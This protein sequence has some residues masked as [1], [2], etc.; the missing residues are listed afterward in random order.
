M[1]ERKLD[2]KESL[3]LI[4]QM[5]QNTRRNLDEG[6]GN[7]FLLWGYVC[8]LVTVTVLVVLHLTANPVWMWG[9]FA[10]PLIGSLLTCLMKRKEKQKVTTYTDKV[11]SQ[12]WQILALF[13]MA[14]V[15]VALFAQRT[16][17]ILPLSALLF[18]LGSIF[19]GIVIRYTAFSG[20]PSVGGMLGLHMLLDVLRGEFM[21]SSLWVFVLAIV[22]SM[23]IPGH[24][25]NYKA[26]KECRNNN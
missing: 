17:I 18:S 20:F 7:M 11:I 10:I 12:M 22:F 9:F 25:L 21:L 5:I 24:I 19:T 1:E 4:S 26:R 8:A 14:I 6:S 23:I 3:E 2:E 16:D 15:M 13:C